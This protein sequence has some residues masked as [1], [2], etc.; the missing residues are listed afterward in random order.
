MIQKGVTNYCDYIGVHAYGGQLRDYEIRK[1]WDYLNANPNVP[2]RPIIASEVGSDIN[3]A[4]AGVTDVRQWQADWLASAQAQFKRFGYARVILFESTN[5]NTSN[6]GLENRFSLFRDN[7][8]PII[9]T[10]YNFLKSNYTSDGLANGDFEQPNDYKTGWTVPRVDDPA[11]ADWSAYHMNNI[12]FAAAG[13]RN[14][15]RA[16]KLDT[17]NAGWATPLRT[18]RIIGG[19]TPGQTYTISAWA[20]VNSSG[21]AYMDIQGHDATRGDAVIGAETSIAGSWQKLTV[22]VTPSNPWVSVMLWSKN[23]AD[24]GRQWVMF[25]DV[26]ISGPGGSGLQANYFSNRT[27]SGSPVASRTDNTVVF[28]WG[29]NNPAP[30]VA[31]DDYSIRWEGQVQ[32]IE[33]GTYQFQTIS[34]DGVRLWV[35]GQLVVDNWSDHGPTANTSGNISLTAGQRVATKMEYYEATGGATAKLLWKRPGMFS[36][37]AIPQWQLYPT[38]APPIGNG[39]GLAA[40][41]FDNSDFTGASKA[42]TDATVNFDWGTGSPDGTIGADSFS[43]R[44][45]GEVQAMEAGTYQFQTHSDD[46][47]RLWVNGA[48]VINNWSDHG[49][50]YDTSGNVTLSAGQ[51]V[52]IRMEFY[53][54]SGGATA[55][56]LWKRPGAGSFEITPQTQ[57]YPAAAPAGSVTE[58]IWTGISGTSVANIPTSATPNQ[59]ATLTA[60][61]IPSN[62]ADNYGVRIRGYLT[63]AN[64]GTYYFWV[65]G[66][67]NSEFYLSTNDNP[68]N[69]SRRCYV[70]AW[71]GS[72]EWYK[73]AS[74]KSAGIA[75]TADTRYYFEVL[76][77]E[78][79]GGDNL[80]VAWKLN[81]SANPVNGSGD[82]IIGNGAWATL[83]SYTAQS[84]SKLTGTVIGTTSSWD[85]SSDRT[86]AFDGNLNTWFDPGSSTTQGNQWVGLDLGSAKTITSVKYAPRAGFVSRITGAQIQVSNAANFATY[87]TAGTI[88]AAPAEGSLTTMTLNVSGTWRYVRITGASNQWFNIAEMEVFG[89]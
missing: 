55:K 32:A 66:D 42:R 2:R 26:T 64:S 47:V 41:Y 44:W 9:S 22:T 62:T 80:A 1:P 58:E 10:T 4:P 35:N 8:G 11:S 37:Q 12:D 82:N 17:G 34:D 21:T 14:G 73:E 77:K 84:S 61:E 52:S 30:G 54:N 46:G 88:S 89:Y 24:Y 67:D 75:L 56:L 76:M 38:G 6:G 31:A 71:T 68:A 63:A 87:T 85:A 65:A 53:E 3:D 16:L 33:N 72:R 86:K 70:S 50:T 60:L 43:A 18:Q 23:T 27:L 39:T 57:L 79:G 69:K 45:E 40:T 59:T 28:D 81:D 48:Q 36:F 13:G 5:V 49:P 51:K 19:L 25:D 74:Q 83:A 20:Y 78:G 15:S 7:A 29:N